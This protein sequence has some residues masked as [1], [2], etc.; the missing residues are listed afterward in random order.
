MIKSNTV[1]NQKIE[2]TKIIEIFFLGGGGGGKKVSKKSPTVK[3]RE[4]QVMELLWNP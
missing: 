3:S 4:M 1:I 2:M